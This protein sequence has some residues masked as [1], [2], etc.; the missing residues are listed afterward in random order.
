MLIDITK[1]ATNLCGYKIEINIKN[2]VIKSSFWN[3]AVIFSYPRKISLLFMPNC[4]ILSA[5]SLLQQNSD[6]MLRSDVNTRY[7]LANRL[8]G[9]VQ[10]SPI[11]RQQIERQDSGR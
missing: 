9:G 11:L 6:S 10:V 2:S 5:V 3:Q 8:E 4:K 1:S 7:S